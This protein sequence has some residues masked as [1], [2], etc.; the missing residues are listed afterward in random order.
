VD[1]VIPGND[2]ALRSIRLFAAGIADAVLAGRGIAESA[3]AEEMP[4]ASAK[5]EDEAPAATPTAS[6]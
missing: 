3:S 4:A 5:S 2:D 1:F 6:V